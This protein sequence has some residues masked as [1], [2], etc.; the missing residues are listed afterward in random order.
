MA[1]SALTVCI[2]MHVHCTLGQTNVFEKDH[3]PS[4]TAYSLQLSMSKDAVP[5]DRLREVD[6]TTSDPPF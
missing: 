5:L 4:R 3:P 2:G 6:P 1:A